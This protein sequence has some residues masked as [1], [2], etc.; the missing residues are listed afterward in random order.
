M[1]FFLSDW[2]AHLSRRLMGELKVYQL[3]RRPSVYEMILFDVILYFPVNSFS[4]MSGRV[5][6]G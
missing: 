6:L 2:I 4:V 3:L 5:F 1:F